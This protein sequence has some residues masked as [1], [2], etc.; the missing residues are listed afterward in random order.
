MQ[1]RLRKVGKSWSVLIQDWLKYEISRDRLRYLRIRNRMEKLS[2]G[3]MSNS[4]VCLWPYTSRLKVAEEWPHIGNYI[5]RRVIRDNEFRFADHRDTSDAKDISIIIGHRGLERLDLLLATL[6]SLAAQKEVGIECIVVE[7]DSSSKIQ[8]YLPKW[9][10]YIF[11]KTEGGKDNYNRSAAFNFGAKNAQGRVLI[12]HDNDMI[13]PTSYCY[14][15]LQLTK[16]SYQ[17]LNTK[18]FVFYLSEQDTKKALSSLVSIK[19]SVPLYIVQN[20]EAG[21]SMAITREAYF[22]IGG[23][24]ENF[25]GWGGEDNEFWRRCS[26]LKRW[27]WGFSPIIHLW[28]E[29]QPLK[30][31]TRN[32]N[33]ERA[34]ILE[35]VTIQERIRILREQNQFTVSKT[36]GG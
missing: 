7:Q 15:I 16:E 22:A 20:L 35:Q 26:H 24:D 11:Q 1:K 23:M 8:S 30:R 9:V 34:K 4:H 25:V 12:L 3:P 33:V 14:D 17:A 5:L 19:S 2:V 36:N 10:R 32:E 18:R 29:S 31:N 21:G 28:H 27:I 13:V 6:K